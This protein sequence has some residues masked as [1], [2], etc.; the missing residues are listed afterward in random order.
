MKS[1]YI[2]NQYSQTAQKC[3]WFSHMYITQLEQW[4]QAYFTSG[5]VDNWAA[6]KA[7]EKF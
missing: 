5:N 2:P 4:M 3:K 6:S 1:E 7:S